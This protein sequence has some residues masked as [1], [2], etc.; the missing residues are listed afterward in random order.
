[1][2]GEPNDFTCPRK[3][4]VTEHL[5]QRERENERVWFVVC[6]KSPRVLSMETKL[7]YSEHI[8]LWAS[9]MLISSIS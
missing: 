9:Q 8:L 1:M 3:H 2:A 6:V 4:R 5:G 7:S